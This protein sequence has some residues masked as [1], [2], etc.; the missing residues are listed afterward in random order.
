L[1][2][3]AISSNSFL[4]TVSSI[5]N[6]AAW[7]R[8]CRSPRLPSV[9]IRSAQRFASLALGAV[10]VMRSCRKSDVT[11]LRSMARRCDGVFPSLRTPT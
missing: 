4:S 3:G 2:P 8:A 9:I 7:R 1:N 10:V 5:T 6:V 11:M